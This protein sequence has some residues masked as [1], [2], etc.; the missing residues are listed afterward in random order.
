MSTTPVVSTIIVSFNTAE[1]TC[2]AVESVLSEY[3]HSNILGELIVVDNNSTDDSI[4]QLQKFKDH[5]QIIRSTKNLGFSGGNNIGISKSTGQYIFLLNS[6]AVVHVGAIKEFISLFQKYPDK[7]T[8]EQEQTHLIDRLGIVSGKLLNPDGTLQVQ[9]GALP[10][11]LSLTVWWLFP[12]PFGS[13]SFPASISYHIE[14]K[15]FFESEQQIGW[16]G[17]TALFIRREVIDEIGLLDE[18]IFMYAE[19]VEY[20]LRATKHHWDIVFTPD[21]QITHLGSASSHSSKALVSEVTGLKYVFFKHFPGWK[22]FLAWK[23]LKLGALLRTLLFGIIQG[24]VE[25]KIL[26]QKIFHNLS[27]ES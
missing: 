1:L 26:Y 12:L 8:A 6:D 21:A 11:L 19:D 15:M 17:G 9:G 22:A 4:Q 27:A 13:D 16:L 7:D 18:G 10:S 2:K 3:K 14:N 25:K 20:C 23:I 5:I 24:D